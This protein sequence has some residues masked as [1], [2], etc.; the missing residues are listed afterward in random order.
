MSS[1]FNNI[2]FDKAD[3]IVKSSLDTISDSRVGQVSSVEESMVARGVELFKKGLKQRRLDSEQL[4][5][6]TV[7]TV[8]MIPS[9]SPPFLTLAAM[10]GVF[11][12]AFR[13]KI[14]GKGKSLSFCFM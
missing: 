12:N 13:K 5:L 7:G 10:S 4:K 2:L 1:I 6:Q 11:M 8:L 3:K 9:A 14:F